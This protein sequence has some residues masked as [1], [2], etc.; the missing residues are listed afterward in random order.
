[1]MYNYFINNILNLGIFFKTLNSLFICKINPLY[2][3]GERIHPVLA[4]PIIF[5]TNCIYIHGDRI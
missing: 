4:G 1:M 5:T 2:N 3:S